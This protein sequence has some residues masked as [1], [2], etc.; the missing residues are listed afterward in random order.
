MYASLALIVAVLDPVLRVLEKGVNP[1]AVM[2]DRERFGARDYLENVL[3]RL[4]E[5]VFLYQV[6]QFHYKPISFWVL[7][8]FHN[9]AT[10]K[11]VSRHLEAPDWV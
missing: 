4:S 5:D 3:A 9:I 10:G 7:S 8:N 2:E 1:Q 11:G 6:A